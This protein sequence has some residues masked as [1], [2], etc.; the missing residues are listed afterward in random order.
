[1][2]Q[3]AIDD[4]LIYKQY[5]YDLS[6]VMHYDDMVHEVEFSIWNR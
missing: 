1:M 3:F 2:S 4:K 6:S 5:P